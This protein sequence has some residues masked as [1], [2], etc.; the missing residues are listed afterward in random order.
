MIQRLFALFHL[1][2][3]KCDDKVLFSL[4]GE[5]FFELVAA[6]VLTPSKV[7]FSIENQTPTIA[8]TTTSQKPYAYLSST[9][10]LS[11]AAPQSSSRNL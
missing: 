7:G 1:F 8:T 5:E 9:F 6:C 10:L 3:E 2:F 4:C 11:N